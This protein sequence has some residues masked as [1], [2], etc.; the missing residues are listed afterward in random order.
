MKRVVVPELLD[1]DAGTPAEVQGSLADLRMVNRWFGGAGTTR[2]LVRK[3]AKARNLHRISCLEVAAGS[4]DVPATVRDRLRQDGIELQITLLDRALTHLNHGAHR[5][6]GDALHLPFRDGSFDLISSGLFA[7]HLEPGQVISF[8]NEGLRVARVAVLV[9]DLIRDPLH[10]VLIY[11]GF[12]LYRSRLTR[13][14]APASVR[15]AYTVDEMNEML[16]QTEAARVE[17]EPHYLFRMGAIAWR[18]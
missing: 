12:P 16:R 9:N 4:G 1:T 13:H 5:V 6:V 11:A 18:K 2:T 7:H 17:I 3:V 8:V 15:R 10:L 14:D